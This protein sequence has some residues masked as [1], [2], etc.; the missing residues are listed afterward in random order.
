MTKF[1]FFQ[2]FIFLIF[3]QFIVQ[4]Q[5]AKKMLEKE[6]RQVE[7]S[8]LLPGFAISVFNSDSILYQKGFGNSDLGKTI[9]F[10]PNNIQIVA[11]ITKTLVGLA[12]MKAAEDQLLT[13]DDPINAILPFQVTN[14]LYPNTPITIRMLA[15]HS[16]SIGSTKNSDKGYRFES[17]LLFEDF[18]EAYIPLLENY[19]KTEAMSMAVFLERKLSSDGAWYEKG[20]FMNYEPGTSYEYSNLGITLLAYILELKTGVPF[21]E[22]TKELILGPLKMNASTWDVNDVSIE[23]HVSYYNEIYNSIPK[24][25]IISYPDGGLYSSVADMTKYLQEMMRGYEGRSKLL[26]QESFREMMTKQYKGEG[27][28]DGLCWDLSFDGLIGHAGND[29]GTATLMYFS[30]KTG[31]GRILFTNISIETEEQEEAFYG[32]FNTLFSYDFRAE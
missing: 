26:S 24:Y 5:G 30:P 4:A 29:F 18:P 2:L 27:L 7:E 10:E 9:P 12:L 31:I 21:D 17:P 23:L 28:D 6:L 16:S 3:F 32:I 1:K 20:V 19:N 8:K 22:F 13:L 25:H 14:P 11:S 15:S